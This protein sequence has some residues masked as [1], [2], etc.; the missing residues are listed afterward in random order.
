M[1]KVKKLLCYDTP[2]IRALA[3]ATPLEKLHYRVPGINQLLVLLI[4]NFDRRVH[5]GW[6]KIPCDKRKTNL[7]ENSSPGDRLHHIIPADGSEMVKNQLSA[8]DLV[9]R[10]DKSWRSKKHI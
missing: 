9:Y 7:K 6:V 8:I 10:Y 3:S 2:L 4:V 5:L 1:F